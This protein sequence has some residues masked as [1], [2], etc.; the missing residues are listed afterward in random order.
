MAQ[1]I[2]S[3]QAQPGVT[4]LNL[5]PRLRSC[6]IRPPNGRYVYPQWGRLGIQTFG[7]IGGSPQWRVESLINESIRLRSEYMTC[8]RDELAT[9]NATLVLRQENEA[10]RSADARADAERCCVAYFL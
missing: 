9:C 1:S 6:E 4:F 2:L 7:G 10:Q 8:V 5:N 3:N